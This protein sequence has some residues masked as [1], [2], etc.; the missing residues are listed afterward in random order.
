VARV[1]PQKQSAIDKCK[2]KW[3]LVLDADERIPPETALVIG[4]IV[5]RGVNDVAGYNFPAE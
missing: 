1:R 2:N 3:V 4:D 5:S